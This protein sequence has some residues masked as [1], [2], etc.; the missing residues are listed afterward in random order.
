MRKQNR[1]YRRRVSFGIWQ[2]TAVNLRIWNLIGLMTIAPLTKDKG[3]IKNSF[4]YLR[5]LRDELNSRGFK[6][7]RAFDGND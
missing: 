3:T 2:N 7:K 1:E 6:S 4:L 5:S